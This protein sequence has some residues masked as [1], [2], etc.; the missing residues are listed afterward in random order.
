MSE[1]P[2]KLVPVKKEPEPVTKKPEVRREKGTYH[3]E[4]VDISLNAIWAFW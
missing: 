2:K 3:E 4:K 1:L